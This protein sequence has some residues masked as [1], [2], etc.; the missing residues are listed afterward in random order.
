MYAVWYGMDMDGIYIIC[1]RNKSVC[2]S[3]PPGR[4]VFRSVENNYRQPG[5]WYGMG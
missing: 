5:R 2:V 3:L 4:A 1:N